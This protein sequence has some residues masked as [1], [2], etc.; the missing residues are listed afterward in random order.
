MGGL[1]QRP[2]T[3]TKRRGPIA[4][5]FVTPGPACVA[6]P[7]LTGK[8]MTDSKKGRAPAFSFGSRHSNKNDSPGPGPGQYNVSGLS[9]K[10]KDGAPAVSLHGRTKTGK[11]EITPAPGDYDPQKA[12][13]MIADTSPKFSFGIKTQN[14]KVDHTPAPNVYNI[15]SA[16]LGGTKESNIKTAPAFSISGR[17]KV[18]TDDRV[19]VPGPGSYESIKADA[20]RSKSPAYS[21]SARFQPH[22]TDSS[23]Q[24]P[25]PGAHCPEKVILDVPPA[26]T[27]GIRHSPYICNLKDAVC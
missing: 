15:P 7:P 12:E 24:T 6:L 5:E 1:T 26:H 22:G 17:Q 11:I 21:M 25:G 13:K 3:P 14:E 2:W 27:F 16:L 19:L 20:I 8:T 4:A 9:S 18:F 23:H 10:G